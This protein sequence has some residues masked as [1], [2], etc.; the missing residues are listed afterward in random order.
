MET[1]NTSVPCSIYIPLLFFHFSQKPIHQSLSL[2]EGEQDYVDR[3]K[4]I[5]LESLDSLGINCTAVRQE[6]FTLSFHC[7]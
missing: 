5:V 7:F 2:C 6:L 1:I 3:R 4:R